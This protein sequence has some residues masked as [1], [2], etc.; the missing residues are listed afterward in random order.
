[1]PSLVGSEMCIRDRLGD[2][3]LK[4]DNPQL[5]PVGFRKYWLAVSSGDEVVHR[6]HPPTV[7]RHVEQAHP[8]LTPGDTEQTHARTNQTI[9]K[10]ES[11]ETI[12]ITTY[13][14]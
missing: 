7:L 14:Q 11:D 3:L 9:T 5:L 1:M 8:V 6:D 10:V 2:S 12:N 13:L 4:Q